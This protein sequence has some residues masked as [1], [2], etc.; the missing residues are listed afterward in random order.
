VQFV[1]AQLAAKFDRGGAPLTTPIRRVFPDPRVRVQSPRVRDYVKVPVD[2][3]LPIK[4]LARAK[5][6]L[7]GAADHGGGDPAAHARLVVAL[8]RDTIAAAAGASLVRRAV[9]IC[10]DRLVCRILAEDGIETIA[11]E[12]GGC[13][14][15]ALRYGET[16]LR[17]AD[18]TTVVAALPADLPA[19]RS[20][21]LDCAVHDA[22]VTGGRAFCADQGRTGT[23]L[24]LALPGHP[25]D[26][27]F[28]SGS[29]AAHRASG[30]R[31]LTGHWPGLRC[32]VDT[33]ADLSRAR[34]LSLGRFTHDLLHLHS[35]GISPRA[36]SIVYPCDIV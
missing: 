35:A 6:R 15:C 11:D 26:P 3:L 34:E 21:E 5:T 8:A 18:P 2:L 4:P 12:P 20:A 32:D 13:L 36:K 10:T 27:R 1:L 23:T 7:R 22:L 31:P 9:A 17:A 25:L 30:A 16:L 19:L 28:G 24:L 14:N 33:A 29:A